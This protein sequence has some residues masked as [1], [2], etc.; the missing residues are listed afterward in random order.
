MR[1]FAL[2]QERVNAIAPKCAERGINFAQLIN[3]VNAVALELGLEVCR[4]E[5]GWSYG[6]FQWRGGVKL[7]LRDRKTGEEAEVELV[8]RGWRNT[9]EKV[10]L[11]K[12]KLLK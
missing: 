7:L 11:R 3:A 5:H 4:V 9:V 12:P 1:K 8:M 10:W 6:M 2:L